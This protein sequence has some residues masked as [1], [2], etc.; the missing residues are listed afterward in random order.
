[1]RAT[2]IALKT[3][4]YLKDTFPFVRVYTEKQLIQVEKIDQETEQ[5]LKI[6]KII[7]RQPLLELSSIDSPSDGLIQKRMQPYRSIIKNRPRQIKKDVDRFIVLG[8]ADPHVV[9]ARIADIMK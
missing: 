8:D 9:E 1:M 3:V 4:S 6:Y 7:K 2:L 5:L